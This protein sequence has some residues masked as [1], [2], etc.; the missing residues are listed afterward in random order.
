MILE[1]HSNG[2]SEGEGIKVSLSDE[3]VRFIVA[4]YYWGENVVSRIS[5]VSKPRLSRVNK[6]ILFSRWLMSRE[7]KER[8]FMMVPVHQ[9]HKRLV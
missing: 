7:R 4:T 9:E 3:N 2:S 8:Q 5:P 1:E 6:N